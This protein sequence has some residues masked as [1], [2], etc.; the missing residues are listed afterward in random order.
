MRKLIWTLFARSHTVIVWKDDNSKVL[1]GKIYKSN[2]KFST[3]PNRLF[4]NTLRSIITTNVWFGLVLNFFPAFTTLIDYATGYSCKS[5]THNVRG[6]N[7][8]LIFLAREK[9]FCAHYST[10]HNSQLI[11]IVLLVE[12]RFGNNSSRNIFATVNN[13]A[14]YNENENSKDEKPKKKSHKK[15]AYWQC[16]TYLTVHCCGRN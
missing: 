15:G 11:I 16:R 7:W 9:Q 2:N 8:K 12:K 4:T 1:I 10:P 13:P 3:A 5:Q 14:D 6:V